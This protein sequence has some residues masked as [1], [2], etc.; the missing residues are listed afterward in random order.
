[1]CVAK[2]L[3]CRAIKFINILKYFNSIYFQSFF[4]STLLSLQIRNLYLKYIH[5]LLSL[6]SD[7]LTSLHQDG[8]IIDLRICFWL[9]FKKKKKYFE[10]KNFIS[11]L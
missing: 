2:C 9:V 10:P 7:K 5:P 11:S 1:M 8:S 3:M 6:S 4:I